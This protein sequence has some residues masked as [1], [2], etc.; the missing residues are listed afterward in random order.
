MNFLSGSKAFIYKI[1][2]IQN[3]VQSTMAGRPSHKV[4]LSL[5]NP[6]RSLQQIRQFCE[7]SE[8]VRLNVKTFAES[9]LNLMIHNICDL[10]ENFTNYE[11]SFLV[12]KSWL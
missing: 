6:L 5:T 8:T 3:S 2:L 9:L 12:L 4:E 10:S 11:K 1:K 7:N